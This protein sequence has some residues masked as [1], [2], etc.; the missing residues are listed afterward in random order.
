MPRG[1]KAVLTEYVCKIAITWHLYSH[2]LQHIKL[3]DYILSIIADA[4]CESISP[5]SRSALD[6]A[7]I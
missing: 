2:K 7:D 4:L 3:S 1:G 5:A 6:P